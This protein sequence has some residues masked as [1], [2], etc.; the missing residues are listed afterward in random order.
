MLLLGLISFAMVRRSQFT[1][2]GEAFL[3]MLVSFPVLAT[4]DRGQV[5]S[6][7]LSTLAWISGLLALPYLH[8]GP[9]VYRHFLQ[10]TLPDQ[11]GQIATDLPLQLHGQ[12]I[13]LGKIVQSIDA[14]DLLVSHDFVNGYMNPLLSSHGGG[15]VVAGAIATVILLWATRRS[16]GDLQFYAFLTVINLYNLRLIRGLAPHQPVLRI[17]AAMPLMV[18]RAPRSSS[19]WL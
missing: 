1:L 7:V 6:L 18:N 17:P 2:P 8:F 9:T 15:A 5:D 13:A 16:P 11:L 10:R 19:L 14:P 4:V 3:F 12:G